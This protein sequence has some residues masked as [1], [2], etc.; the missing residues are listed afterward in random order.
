MNTEE[1]KTQPQERPMQELRRMPLHSLLIQLEDQASSRQR[2]TA[3]ST[4]QSWL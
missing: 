1:H 4:W 3:R 2:P